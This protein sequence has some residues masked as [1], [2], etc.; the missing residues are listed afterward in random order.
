MKKKL[1]LLL[2]AF[3]LISYAQDDKTVNLNV[4]GTGKNVEEAKQNALRSAIEQ[5]F[6]AFISSKTEILNDNL[7]KDEIISVSNGNIQKFDLISEFTTP[8]GDIIITLKALVSISKLTSFVES[9][10]IEIEF[11]GGL[12]SQNV[13]LQQLNDSNEKKVVYELVGLMHEKLQTVF[14]YEIEASNPVLND[15]KINWNIPL[16]V[17]AI[18]N[19]NLSVFANYFIKNLTALSL[20]DNDVYNYKQLKKQVYEVEIYYQEQVYKIYLRDYSSFL[21]L[22]NLTRSWLFYLGCF[23]VDNGI[24]KFDGPGGYFTEGSGQDLSVSNL[25]FLIARSSSLYKDFEFEVD[26]MTWLRFDNGKIQYKMLN[27]MKYDTPYKLIFK[28]PS[29]S[30]IV[31]TYEWNDIK[32][33]NEIEKINNIK[34]NPS[35]VVSEFKHGGYLIYEKD[36]H[37]LVASLF[38]YEIESNDNY[39]KDNT[40]LNTKREF[41]EGKNNTIKIVKANDENSFINKLINTNDN[42]F[43]DWFIPSQ[44]ELTLMVSKLYLSG[45][46]K[47]PNLFS[48][49]EYVHPY[50]K[51]HV[52]Y[53]DEITYYEDFYKK[54]VN[55]KNVSLKNIKETYATSQ[56]EKV[57]LYF[58]F[59][60]LV[61]YF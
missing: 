9:K 47:D 26:K 60:R 22:H 49:T 40:F 57:K 27:Y 46:C 5:A 54:N 51:D 38:S 56:R 8:I 34:V 12:F 17:T 41:G 55:K 1:I 50:Y 15:D 28:I 31:A 52:I 23:Q 42:G 16:K 13:K 7:I 59:F 6:G 32:S 61:R 11:K 29:V 53:Y 4:T 19:E 39:F 48:S 20:N 21:V 14:N 35:G 33:L 37:G 24:D 3:T 43:N 58:P 45:I 2:I 30:S 36:G 44:D 10:G 25:P 18:A